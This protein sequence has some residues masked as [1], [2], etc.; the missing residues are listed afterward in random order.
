MHV[1][2]QAGVASG[3]NELAKVRE[4]ATV[5]KELGGF[6]LGRDLV[7]FRSPKMCPAVEILEIFYKFALCFRGRLR[8]SG[9]D[10]GYREP[11]LE[12]HGIRQGFQGGYPALEAGTLLPHFLDC[13]A[14]SSARPV[15]DLV[16]IRVV[17]ENSF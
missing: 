12:S 13:D 6:K 17:F 8:A 4:L 14:M 2:C 11:R 5:Q 9:E 3:Y 1:Q 15:E 7:S 10:P 16:V